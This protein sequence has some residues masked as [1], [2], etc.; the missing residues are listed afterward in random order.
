MA[1]GRTLFLFF[2]FFFFFF[3]FCPRIIRFEKTTVTFIQGLWCNARQGRSK[4]K[5]P[6]KEK[7]R[8]AATQKRL[9]VEEEWK[10]GKCCGPS[11]KSKFGSVFHL[12]VGVSHA[13]AGHDTEPDTVKS[14]E[15]VQQQETWRESGLQTKSTCLLYQMILS[16]P[17]KRERFKIM[18]AQVQRGRFS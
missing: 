3:F 9:R 17:K 14:H 10:R 1:L 8:D 2:F 18:C 12:T 13:A 16:P 4:V 7:N 15:V 6:L 11:N 5:Q